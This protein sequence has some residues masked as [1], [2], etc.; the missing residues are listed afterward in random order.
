[1]KRILLLLVIGFFAFGNAFSQG[2][3]VSVDQFVSSPQMFDNQMIVLQG[4]EVSFEALP[5]HMQNKGCKVPRSF[6]LLNI[7]FKNARPD[8]KPCFITSSHL[9]KMNA[10]KARGGSAKF[11]LLCKGN[12]MNGYS[13]TAM[14]AK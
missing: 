9:V 2:K 4:V 10:Q 13:V 6:E 12:A 11:D 8:F 14:I 1:M 7:Q 5:P 3:P